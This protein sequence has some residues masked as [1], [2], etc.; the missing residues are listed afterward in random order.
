MNLTERRYAIQRVKE[1]ASHKRNEVRGQRYLSDSEK[2]ALKSVLKYKPVAEIRKEANE[3][4]EG[5]VLR[6]RTT[7]PRQIVNPYTQESLEKADDILKKM[8][9]VPSGKIKL[10]DEE[11]QRICDEIMLG[12]NDKAILAIERF[13]KK[14][15]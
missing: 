2:K 11:C 4:F 15:F 3:M 14:Q 9:A 7:I 1:I 13:T 5:S 10:I 8:G 6:S 12:T